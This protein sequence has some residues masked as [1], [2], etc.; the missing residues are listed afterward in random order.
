MDWKNI[1][2][3]SKSSLPAGIK[4]ILF[5]ANDFAHHKNH[6]KFSRFEAALNDA[7]IAHINQLSGGGAK[8][9]EM[10]SK[11][12]KEAQQILEEMKRG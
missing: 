11:A 12:F 6:P 5:D 8:D 4:P 3:Q 10:G 1:L 2:K 7:N 9:R